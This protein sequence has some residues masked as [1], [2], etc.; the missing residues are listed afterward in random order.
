MWPCQARRRLTSS[1]LSAGL[2]M[3]GSGS[4]WG[5]Q[6]GRGPSGS[7]PARFALPGSREALTAYAFSNRAGIATSP[8]I[9]AEGPAGVYAVRVRVPGRSIGGSYDWQLV[10]R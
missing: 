10:V 9:V 5:R 1:W 3:T 6:P 4:P 8:P 7:V 2:H